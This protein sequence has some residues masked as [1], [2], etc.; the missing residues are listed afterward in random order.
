MK[1]NRNFQKGSA[2]VIV[3]MVAMIMSVVVIATGIIGTN[4]LSMVNTDRWR[5]K[6]FYIAEAGIQR[7]KLELNKNHS[8]NGTS[9]S[10]E[11]VKMP[12][13]QGEYTV[14]VYNNVNGTTS[15]ITP[16]GI[17]IPPGFAQIISEGRY[18]NSVSCVAMTAKLCSAFQTALFAKKKIRII[19]DTQIDAYDSE[20]GNIVPGEGS[21]GTNA[22]CVDVIS[23]DGSS[24]RI[25][26]S[27]FIGPGGNPDTAISISGDPNITGDERIF[28]SQIPMPKVNVPDNLPVGEATSNTLSPGDYSGQ[29]VLKL[30]GGSVVNLKGPGEYIF[31]GLDV[32]SGCNLNVDTSNG[33]VKIYLL[34]NANIAGDS[35]VNGL[36]NS[37]TGDIKARPTNLM[38][39]GS[40]QTTEMNLKGCSSSNFAIY[41]PSAQV[42]ISGTSTL[43]GSI[44]AD[45]IFVN[46][47]SSFHF[48]TALKR[49]DDLTIMRFVSWNRF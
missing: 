14:K 26:G 35:T 39:I 3:L 12:S 45:S 1:T 19:G 13:G 16:E 43:Y 41:A 10:F 48:D 32:S 31:D 37:T 8:W 33:Q 44:V 4:H 47:T 28:P 15:M 7:A 22:D 20:T 38:I 30:R 6:A 17:E 29:G 25:D 27:L 42:N 24:V 2:V 11:N 40:E 5:T 34:G 46:G 9:P 18:L 36:T 21:V 23:I 49:T